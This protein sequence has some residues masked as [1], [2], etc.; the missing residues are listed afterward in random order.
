MASLTGVIVSGHSAMSA[1]HKSSPDFALYPNLT[2]TTP[3]K[4]GN[5]PIEREWQFQQDPDGWMG[6]LLMRNHE[7]LGDDT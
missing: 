5:L 1:A 6:R 4:V 3:W 7:A 2:A